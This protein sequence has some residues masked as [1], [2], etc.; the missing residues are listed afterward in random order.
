[1]LRIDTPDGERRLVDVGFGGQTPTSPLRFVVDEPQDTDHEQFR[2]THRAD[3]W[4]APSPFVMETLVAGTWRP[5]YLFA[6]RPRPRIDLEV[7]SWF[8]STQPT[9]HFVTGLNAAI[10]TDDARWNLR[11]RNLSVH[12]RDGHTEKTRLSSADEVA[13]LLG[14]RFGIDVDSIDGLSATL[15]AVL[16]T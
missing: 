9:S 3:G 8:V 14:A 5:V 11:G 13:A 2:I 6:D 16:D 4:L 1:M 10:V 7:A 15:P 12:H